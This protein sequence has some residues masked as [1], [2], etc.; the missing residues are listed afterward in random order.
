MAGALNPKDPSG[1]TITEPV[2]SN[3]AMGVPSEAV[4]KTGAGSLE[5]ARKYSIINV[6]A[7][8][9]S[10]RKRNFVPGGT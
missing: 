3:A 4:A 7:A 9:C 2:L 8:N 6:S 5:D 1:P 10:Q